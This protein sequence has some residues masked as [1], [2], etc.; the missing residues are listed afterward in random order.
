MISGIVSTR[1]AFAKGTVICPCEA[2]RPFAP[3]EA[4]SEVRWRSAA[5][6]PARPE[7]R[8]RCQVRGREIEQC[9]K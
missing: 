4:L 3:R 7:W 6:A 9:A 5:A 2:P 8:N 1:G